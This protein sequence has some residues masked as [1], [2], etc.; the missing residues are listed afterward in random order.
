M[1]IIYTMFHKTQNVQRRSQMRFNAFTQWMVSTVSMSKR[2]IS[3]YVETH[4]YDRMYP[5][6]LSLRRI[7]K[8]PS[9]LSLRWSSASL[10]NTGQWKIIPL[11]QCFYN[12]RLHRI[13]LKNLTCLFVSYTNDRGAKIQ[14][15][16]L[17]Y[18]NI[19]I[20]LQ[21]IIVAKVSNL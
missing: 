19:Q 5:V 20:E 7:R 16:A 13:F 14:H 21:S 3:W 17:W 12:N 15:Q 8:Q 9:S 2:E 10:Y 4:R 6:A 11:K 1:Q 18:A